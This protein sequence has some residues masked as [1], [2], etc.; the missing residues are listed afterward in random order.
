MTI[1]PDG[2]IQAVMSPK[3]DSFPYGKIADVGHVGAAIRA[4]RRAIGM[5]QEELASL[6]G[7]GARFLSEVENGKPS[8]EIGKVLQV[9]KR[10]GL[11]LSIRP[12]GG[13]GSAD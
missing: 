11:E 2:K 9:L 4:K 1:F 12:R 6:S 5:R 8:A 10:L 7:V 3:P 13:D